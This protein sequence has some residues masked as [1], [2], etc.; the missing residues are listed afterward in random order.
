MYLAIYKKERKRFKKEKGKLTSKNQQF[1]D[2]QNFLFCTFFV[3]TF[4]LE[5]NSKTRRYCS[6]CDK[7]QRI[8]PTFRKKKKISTF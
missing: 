2:F 1:T 7:M 3:K 6:I 4:E 5:K 8:C